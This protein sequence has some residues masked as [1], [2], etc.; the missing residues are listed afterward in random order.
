ME[1]CSGLDGLY[2]RS[3]SP[4]Q[5]E[6]RE[7]ES[8][9]PLQETP[10]QRPYKGRWPA[11]SVVCAH[12]MPI[13]CPWPTCRKPSFKELKC[14]PDVLVWES[15]GERFNRLVRCGKGRRVRESC[16]PMAGLTR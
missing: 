7:F 14:L 1:Y 8:R 15:V 9:H 3:S 4:C 10:G 2:G 11:F 5:G 6:G 13:A 16:V 12:E